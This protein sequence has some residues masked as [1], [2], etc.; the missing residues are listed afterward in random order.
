MRILPILAVTIQCYSSSITHRKGTMSYD[1]YRTCIEA[2]NDCAVECENCASECIDEDSNEMAQCIHH[3]LDCSLICAMAAKL[4]ARGS[5]AI[6]SVCHVCAEA[7]RRCAE[8][9]RKHAVE[10]CRRCAEACEQCAAE[11]ERVAGEPAMA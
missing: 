4:M 1:N 7:C 8:E 5:D 2:C 6:Q 9:C 10:H 3:D 11:C